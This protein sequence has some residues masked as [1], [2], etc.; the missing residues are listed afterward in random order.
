MPQIGDFGRGKSK[1]RPRNDPRLYG[2]LYPFVQTGIVAASQGKIARFDQS[3]TDFGL[4]QSKLWPKGT[5]C[6]TIAANIARTGV[7]AFD[8]CFPDSVVGLTCKE[9]VI[10]EYV[11]LV[12]RSLQAGLEDGAP[13][14]AQ[15]NIN[16]ETLECL[17]I[18][19]PPTVEQNAIVEAHAEASAAGDLLMRGDFDWTSAK[20]RQSILSAAFRGELTA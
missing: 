2:G 16:L 3:Y 18:P 8:A 12:V 6:I 1:H 11:E 15:K 13:A 4:A 5:L 19:L 7:L 20:L 10:P 17:P 9:G 14:T